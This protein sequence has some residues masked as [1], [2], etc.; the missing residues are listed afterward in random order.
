[1]N[2]IMESTKYEAD[3]LNILY[4]R[5]KQIFSKEEFESFFEKKFIKREKL[6]KVY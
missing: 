3:F 1:M 5:N 4:L 2:F 6:W